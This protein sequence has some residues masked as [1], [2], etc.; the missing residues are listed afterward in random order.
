MIKV[1]DKV[2]VVRPHP[3]A[4]LLE[5]DEYIVEVVVPRDT[6]VHTFQGEIE[7]DQE[8]VIVVKDGIPGYPYLWDANR[9]EK[10]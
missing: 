1:G 9:F 7:S 8:L 3:G 10:V 5:G 6:T 2:V 4:A